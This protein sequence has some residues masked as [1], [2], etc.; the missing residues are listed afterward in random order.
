MVLLVLYSPF[1]VFHQIAEFGLCGNGVVDQGED[2][3]C[4]SQ[5]ECANTDP[6]CDPVS[7]R[8][9]REA[10]CSTGPCCDNCK[11]AWLL[12]FLF[13]QLIKCCFFCDNC[14][15]GWRFLYVFWNMV[16]CFCFFASI[17]FFFAV[18]CSSFAFRFYHI[19]WL[20]CGFLLW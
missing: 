10:E 3:D 1:A 5:E 6:C 2:C 19:L 9:K 18:C 20:K 17:I 13:W 16:K 7:C 15:V 8:L 11:V 14:K 4:G 12:I